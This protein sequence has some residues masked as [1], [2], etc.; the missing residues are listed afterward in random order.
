MANPSCH[1]WQP[2]GYTNLCT[3][4]HCDWL[5]KASFEQ[6]IAITLKEV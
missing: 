2:D 1:I 4:T 3:Y 5:W 6:I